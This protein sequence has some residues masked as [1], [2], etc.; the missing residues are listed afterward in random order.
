LKILYF[1]KLKQ[2]IGKSEETICIVKKK[3]ISQVI[4][5]LKKRNEVYNFALKET[6]SLQYAVNCE[7]VDLDFFVTNNDELAI[8]PPVSGG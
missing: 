4:N 7:Y 6:K 5:E 3:K 8:F 1:A 2:L